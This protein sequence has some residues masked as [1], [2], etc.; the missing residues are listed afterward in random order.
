MIWF[1]LI[2][3]FTQLCTIIAICTC[4][5]FVIL[6][7]QILLLITSKIFLFA[8]YFHVFSFVVIQLF[9]WS[10]KKF[11]SLG[12]VRD[13]QYNTSFS[14]YNL[15]RGNSH[16]QP[17]EACMCQ[18]ESIGSALH[19]VFQ[20]NVTQSEQ[21]R[22]IDKMKHL[23]ICVCCNCVCTYCF[24]LNRHMINFILRPCLAVTLCRII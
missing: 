10:N 17:C 4:V 1:D 23:F 8:C 15:H 14:G 11:I 21:S 20:T 9:H 13:D 3:F 12:P 18:H 16:F 24:S 7:S 5:V 6:C 2:W 19:T 22:S